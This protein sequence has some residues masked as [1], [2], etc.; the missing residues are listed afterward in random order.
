MKKLI[1]LMSFFILLSCSSESA[2]S[3]RKQYP[4]C[5]TTEIN[6]IMENYSPRTPKSTVKKYKYNEQFIYVVAINGIADELYP[7]YNENCEL[8]C[9]LE[10]LPILKLCRLG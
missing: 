10:E 1:V 4:D 2:Q 6:T 7:V 9:R 5:V 3:E 8:L